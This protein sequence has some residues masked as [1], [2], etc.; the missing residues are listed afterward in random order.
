[1]KLRLYKALGILPRVVDIKLWGY[2]GSRG[3]FGEYAITYYRDLFNHDK[4]HYKTMGGRVLTSDKFWKYEAEGLV[5][6][7]RW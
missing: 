3:E 6:V 4:D 1:M 2:Y 7:V 5:T